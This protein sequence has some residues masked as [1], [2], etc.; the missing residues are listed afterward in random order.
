MKIQVC[1]REYLLTYG[2]APRGRGS[3]AFFFDSSTDP[4][5]AY[6]PSGLT[7]GEALKLAKA[8]AIRRGAIVIAVGT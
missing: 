2:R 4:W 3:W 6:A 5:W 8:E 1:T 7:Y